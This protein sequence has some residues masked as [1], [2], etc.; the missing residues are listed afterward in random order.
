M[1]SANYPR[2]S[3]Y[4]DLETVYAQCSGPGGLKLAEFTK[5]EFVSR[6]ANSWPVRSHSLALAS[7]LAVT[8]L[9]PSGLKLAE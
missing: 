5:G 6:E 2:A 9:V 4:P 1:T 7:A 8:I 3:K